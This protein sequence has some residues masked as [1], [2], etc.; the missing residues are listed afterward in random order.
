MI[1]RNNHSKTKQENM[2]AARERIIRELF[3]G[4]IITGKR[5]SIFDIAKETATKKRTKTVKR[6]ACKKA[7]SKKNSKTVKR[8]ACKKAESKKHLKIE[9]EASPH[10][11]VKVNS[12]G[13]RKAQINWPKGNSKEWER[14]DEDMSKLLHTLYAPAEIR[15]R[16]HPNVIYGMCMERFG[17]KE[18]GPKK[19]QSGPSKRQKKCSKLRE[20]I[21]LLKAAVAEAPIEEKDAI[22]ELQKEKLKKL[23][24]AKRAETLKKNRRK[25][26]KNC[27]EFLSQPYDFARS[28]LSPKPKGEL[29]DSK[30]DVEEFLKA[31]H[32][33]PDREVT[34]E[35]CEGLKEFQQAEVQFDDKL[36]TF[37]EF[38]KK[39]IRTRSNSAPGP[40]GVPYLVYKR[41]PKVAKL[42]W[43]YLKDLW[44]KNL[45]SDT[46]READGIFIPKVDGAKTVG[47]FR[48]ISLLNVEGK[49]FFSLKAD[50]I[51]E[52]V[53]KNRFINTSIQKGGIPNV[54]GCIEH[55][56][57]LSQMIKE[58]K[59][60]DKNLVVTWLDIANAYGSIPH[61]IIS[62]AL[63][64]AHVPNEVRRLIES[65]YNKVN[66]RFTT[67]NFTTAWQRVEKGI[68]TGCT[69]SVILF[70]L[71]MSWLI[72][73]VK[74]ETKGPAVSSGQRQLNS[75]L[76][77]DDITTTTETVPQ[78]KVLLQKISE[79]FTWAGLKVR[80]DKCRSLVIFKGKVQRRDLYI[81]G[82]PITPIQDKP[83]RY[84]GKEYNANLTERDQIAEVEKN[85]TLE[86]RKINKCKIPGKYKSWIFQYMLLPRLMWP[87]TIYTIPISKIENMERIITSAL[88][89]WMGIPKNLSTSCMYSKS[90]KL[91]LPFSSLQEEFKVVKTRNLVT[92]QDSNDPCIQGANIDVDGGR[93]A[94]TGKDIELSKARL[95]MQEII[96]ATNKG[97]EGLGMRKVEFFSKTSPKGKRKMIVKSV[98]EKEEEG[99]V[100]N[101]ASLTK[102]GA[103]LKWEV[104]QR[105]LTQ[106]DLINMPEERIKFLIKSVYD[107]LPTPANKNKWFK[108]EERCLLCGEHSTLNHILAG[109][110]TAL[111]QGRYKWRHDQV[112]KE[113]AN[114]IQMKIVE[115]TKRP[116][117]EKRKKIQFIRSGESCTVPHDHPD[118]FLS[119]AKDWKLSADLV[120]RVKIPAAVSTTDLRPDITIVSAVTKQMVIVE[121]TVPTEDRIEVA[122]QM[123]RLKYQKIVTEGNQN[124]W[125]VKCWAVEV[126][127]RGFPAI[128]MSSFLKDLGYIGKQR[129][130]IVEKLGRIAESASRSLWKASHYREW[131]R[132]N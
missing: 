77:M 106:N 103:H 88:K 46:W 117:V 10:E 24:L 47:K 53:I 28:L 33:D 73:S 93:K 130:Q 75:R 60:M 104:P 51:T 18:R 125:S 108:T 13:G 58:A 64:A 118:S 45:I 27:K 11:E 113:L 122:G 97:K 29:G 39:L 92:F 74:E 67:K 70:A 79:K 126:G 94:N 62:S 86:L 19:V 55:T 21:N 38:R 76:F 23:R 5:A 95:K 114:A 131:G 42:L 115:N 90:A 31:A 61:S 15:A 66:I 99:R 32:S 81:D 17:V 26:A 50:R 54:S 101:I 110:K 98:R 57:I 128:S 89:K 109:C 69:L 43:M 85:L 105:R 44:K 68:I 8:N 1:C 9:K 48:T 16:T 80:A 83:V 123:K 25:Y 59:R 112:L 72:E 100:A 52:F 34:K 91:R 119:D 41:C 129:K 3:S 78:T 116:R 12:K 56:A 30:E 2:S 82:D 96:G 20:E 7:E 127:C 6:N 71:T 63:E 120:D 102:Q 132:M 35:R 22:K 107:L 121:L 4:T 87:L 40:N 84:L 111:S 65:Y 36:P 49:L 124:G 37:N 14:L